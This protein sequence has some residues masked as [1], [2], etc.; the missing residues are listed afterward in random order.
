MR[1]VARTEIEPP[2][3]KTARELAVIP[4]QQPSLKNKK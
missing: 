4:V 2:S 1:K 3:I